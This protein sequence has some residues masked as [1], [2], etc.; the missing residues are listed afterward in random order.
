MFRHLNDILKESF[1]FKFSNTADLSY[2]FLVHCDYF[3]ERVTIYD[4]SIAY[5][6]YRKLL[7]KEKLLATY[8][9]MIESLHKV[10][11]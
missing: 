5:I 4:K 8:I 7:S 1:I 11:V 9:N 10:T 3:A 2:R 6:R